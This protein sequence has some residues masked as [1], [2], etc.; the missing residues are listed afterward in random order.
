MGLFSACAAYG[1]Y[2]HYASGKKRIIARCATDNHVMDIS[3]EEYHSHFIPI[4]SIA[5]AGSV[6]VAEH[7]ESST[8]PQDSAMYT[9]LSLLIG[10]LYSVQECIQLDTFSFDVPEELSGGLQGS[11]CL[12]R[13]YCLSPN[14]HHMHMHLHMH[15]SMRTDASRC[16]KLARHPGSWRWDRG[17]MHNA[18][19]SRIKATLRTLARH[20]M[21]TGIQYTG[22]AV[23]E[24][25]AHTGRHAVQSI[26]AEKGIE[27]GARYST[28]VEVLSLIAFMSQCTPSIEAYFSH[29]CYK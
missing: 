7:V 6:D 18:V 17:V 21:I 9:S 22:I 14:T 29:L 23:L 20:T 11:A 4:V 28:S 2:T 5:E 25:L 24:G 8:T 16:M 15:T 3:Q 27:A 1:C 10:K 19:T 12:D 26:V 13:V